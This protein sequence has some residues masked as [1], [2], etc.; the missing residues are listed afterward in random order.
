MVK[1]ETEQFYLLKCVPD[2]AAWFA[3]H[4]KKKDKYAST[5]I[6]STGDHLKYGSAR[7]IIQNAVEAV[8]KKKEKIGQTRSLSNKRVFMTLMRKKEITLSHKW[9]SPQLSKK[10]H[11]PMQIL[12]QKVLC[13]SKRTDGKNIS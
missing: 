11:D 6:T 2:L 3:V 8:I 9:M 1:R 13:Y 4:S 5:W 12:Y 10:R 7:K